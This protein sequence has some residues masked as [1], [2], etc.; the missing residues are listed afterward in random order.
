MGAERE[1]KGGIVTGQLYAAITKSYPNR[2]YA[3]TA[4]TIRGWVGGIVKFLEDCWEG[5]AVCG[6]QA[7]KPAGGKL[8]KAHIT[9]PPAY[10]TSIAA[11]L[12]SLPTMLVNWLFCQSKHSWVSTPILQAILSSLGGGIRE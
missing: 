3:A 9:Q 2:P 12:S 11:E 7:T 4:A 8:S 6:Y 10:F 5:L 1:Q